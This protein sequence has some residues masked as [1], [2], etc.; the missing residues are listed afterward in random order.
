MVVAVLPLSAVRLDGLGMARTAPGVCYGE[1]YSAGDVM[2]HPRELMM[3]RT[4]PGMRNGTDLPPGLG[5]E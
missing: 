5:D 1:G 2:D 3:T 4:A